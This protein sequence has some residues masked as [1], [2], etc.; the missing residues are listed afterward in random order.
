M[1]QDLEFG[2]LDNQYRKKLPQSEASETETVAAEVTE[3]A[4]AP[5]EIAE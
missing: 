3:T 1:L 4:E 5:A 2:H